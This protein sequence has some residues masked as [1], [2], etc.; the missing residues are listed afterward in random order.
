MHNITGIFFLYC[1]HMY[2][3]NQIHGL[4]WAENQYRWC[5]IWTNVW[6][7]VSFIL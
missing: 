3:R 1:R 2:T 5:I 4:S 6:H 7:T